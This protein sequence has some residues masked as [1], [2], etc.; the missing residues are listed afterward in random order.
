[1]LRRARGASPSGE[2]H[3]GSSSASTPSGVVS[4]GGGRR[5]TLKRGA[6]PSSDERPDPDHAG[7]EISTSVHE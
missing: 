7:F 2:T 4:V 1:M 5:I 6:V 3:A